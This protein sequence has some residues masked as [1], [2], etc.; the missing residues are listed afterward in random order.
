MLSSTFANFIVSVTTLLII[1][2]YLGDASFPS[3]VLPFV[4][5]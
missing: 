5:A 2:A 3:G 1:V 4:A